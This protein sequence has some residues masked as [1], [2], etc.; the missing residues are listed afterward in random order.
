MKNILL[1]LSQNTSINKEYFHS[2][3]RKQLVKKILKFFVST[4]KKNKQTLEVYKIFI[5]I[6][7]ILVFIL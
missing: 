2:H 5:H 3:N 1:L 7:Y 6:I 4:I